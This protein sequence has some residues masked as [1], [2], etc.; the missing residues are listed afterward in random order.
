MFK[1]LEKSRTDYFVATSGKSRASMEETRFRGMVAERA[2]FKAE[3]RDFAPGREWEDW[4][5]AERE[6]LGLAG[7]SGLD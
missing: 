3:R 2:Y 7:A 6:L 4:F 1:T 5:E